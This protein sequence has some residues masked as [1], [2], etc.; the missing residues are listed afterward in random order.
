MMHKALYA[1][2]SRLARV[3]WV[4]V[5]VAGGCQPAASPCVPYEQEEPADPVELRLVQRGT[6]TLLL[7]Q[8]YE[9]IA[10]STVLPDGRL[11]PRVQRHSRVLPWSLSSMTLAAIPHQSGFRLLG[12]FASS[13]VMPEQTAEERLWVPYRAGS[14]DLPPGFNLEQAYPY[15][16]AVYVVWVG[17]DP[18][19]STWLAGLGRLTDDDVVEAIGPPFYSGPRPLGVEGLRFTGGLDADGTLWVDWPRYADHTLPEE[20]KVLH[21]ALDGTVLSEQPIKTDWPYLLSWSRLPS[22][23]W[24]GLHGSQLALF[25]VSERP[26]PGVLAL[27]DLNYTDLTT[28]RVLSDGALWLAGPD[29]RTNEAVLRR[30]D[31]ASS[32]LGEEIR[33]SLR[34]TSRHRVGCAHDGR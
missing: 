17:A 33:S 24:A 1:S 8:G 19:S 12:P 27:P 14:A 11:E 26:H 32:T 3:L 10:W 7:M 22:G 31:D 20:R 34:L 2:C 21:L 15:E 30:F 16:G 23:R 9:V 6:E 18:A 5:A 13:Y 4:A 25:S 28:Q 29:D